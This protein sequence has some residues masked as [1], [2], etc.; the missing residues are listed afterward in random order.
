MLVEN[1]PV[2]PDR[3]VWPE[4]NTLRDYGFQV[5]IIS[6]KGAS[7]HREPY[8]CIDGIHIYRYQIPIIEHKYI[9]HIAEYGVA[10]VMTFWLSV[11][12]Y[13]GMALT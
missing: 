11:K 5:S 1:V 12:F 6:P 4:A 13:F 9:G 3:R 2:P 10:L 7:E 8:I